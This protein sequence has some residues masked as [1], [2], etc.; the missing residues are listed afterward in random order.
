MKT[1][2]FKVH[3][4]YSRKDIVRMQ[5]MATRRNRRRTLAALIVVLILYVGLMILNA[6]LA[7]ESISPVSFIPGG[8]LDVILLAA[9]LF[10]IVMM[11]SAPYFQARK[12]IRDAPGGELK[13]NIY[14]YDQTFKYGWGNS[15]TTTAY[16][17]ISE[18]RDMGD[19]FYIKAGER[20]FWIRKPDFE[21]GEA[22]SFGEFMT[23]KS[24][25]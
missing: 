15:F 14:F 23:Q 18:F 5:K 9:M 20:S 11:V 2:H 25:I 22:D 12:I 24:K 17:E 3:S 16:M 21:I 8:T 4:V 6:L 1:I 7:G 10:A 19:A 13:A